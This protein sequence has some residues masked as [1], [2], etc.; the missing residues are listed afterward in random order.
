MSRLNRNNCDTHIFIKHKT[1]KG[2]GYVTEEYYWSVL[3]FTISSSDL[4]SYRYI[5]K[6]R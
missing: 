4:E 6:I 2:L 3:K 5:F 1:G